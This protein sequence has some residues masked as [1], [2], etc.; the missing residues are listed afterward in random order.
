M[1]SQHIMTP[2]GPIPVSKVKAIFEQVGFK[3]PPGMPIQEAFMLLMQLMQK[4]QSEEP[5]G[6]VGV[7]EEDITD[8]TNPMAVVRPPAS[9]YLP[10][11]A[12]E[13]R[14]LQPVGAEVIGL[15]L[16]DK[17]SKETLKTLQDEMSRAGFL[18]FRN[19]GI[20]HGDEQVSI[21]EYFGGCEIHSTHGS[22]P[23]APNRHI[24]RLSNEDEH[25]INGVGPQWHNDGSFC[26]AVF[27][28]V[29]YHMVRCPESG[30]E[31]EFADLHSAYM[32]LPEDTQ[33]QW[34]KYTSVNS[35][36]GVLHPMVYEHPIS[37]QTVIYLHLGMT[38]AVIETDEAGTHRTLNKEEMTALFNAYN[39]LLQ[40]HCISFKYQSGDLVIID[41]LA[42]AHRASPSAHRRSSGLRILHRTT[43]KGMINHDPLPETGLEHEIDMNANRGRNPFDNGVWQGGGLGFRWDPNIR[44]Q[45]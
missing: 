35:N 24:F 32:A 18:V 6:K 29:G 39:T 26:R 15:N 44:M 43:I 10:D 1:D 19:Q 17:P 34:R 16:R 36:S 7:P 13:L 30:G 20:L 9:E 25:G 22:H 4:Q 41:N 31:T 40:E 38:G 27:S 2:Q 3:P 45:N 37:K 23:K 33:A 14:A 42:V 21:C 12:Y 28:H 11:G 8:P 5:P